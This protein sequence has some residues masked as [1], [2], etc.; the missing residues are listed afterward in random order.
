MHLL[1]AVLE[2]WAIYFLQDARPYLHHEIRSDA[3]NIRVICGM[4]DLAER[5]S[6]R[7]FRKAAFFA[8]WKDV[9]GVKQ[10][11]LSQ[12]TYRAPAVVGQ[13]DALPEHGLMEAGLGDSLRIMLLCRAQAGVLEKFQLRCI[14]CHRNL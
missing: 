4:V 9:G 8:V 10:R 7:D 11:S 5:Q 12:A 2:H 1:K 14:K 6:V 3:E 13:K